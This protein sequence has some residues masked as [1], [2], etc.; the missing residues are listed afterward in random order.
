[1]DDFNIELGE[2]KDLIK[3]DKG[4]P[5]PI[6]NDC[7]ILSTGSF[8]DVG[9]L[10]YMSSSV[11]DSIK[12]F[13]ETYKHT[14]VG[15]V[16]LGTACMYDGKPCIN[17]LDFELCDSK[18]TSSVAFT[19][20]HDATREM[21][22]RIEAK[23]NDYIKL[24]WWH[25]HPGHGIFLSGMDKHIQTQF[26]NSDF[27]VALVYDPIHRTY[28]FFSNLKG[29]DQKETKYFLFDD[30]KN[31]LKK[32]PKSINIRKPS[33]QVRRPMQSRE[34]QSD[35]Q[36]ASASRTRDMNQ[37]SSGHRK[38]FREKI[39]DVIIYVEII[40]IAILLSII[41]MMKVSSPD[42][43]KTPTI[44]EQQKEVK[45][46]IETS[47]KL[48]K[49]RNYQYGWNVYFDAMENIDNILELAKVSSTTNEINKMESFIKDY[50]DPLW[51][52]VPSIK[53]IEL[54]STGIYLLNKILANFNTDKLRVNTRISNLLAK[55]HKTA[56]KSSADN[57]SKD[58]GS[59]DNGSKDNGNTNK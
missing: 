34:G 45:K 41:M 32:I 52:E 17:I 11:M 26:F 51:N 40:L 18:Q 31:M 6:K 2:S 16:L 47:R 57:G 29:L 39:K 15:G 38:K 36:F 53:R 12:D 21:D 48:F 54:N 8:D 56:D 50:L 33:E 7:M 10:I 58:N 30:E 1:M 59:K 5:Y 9:L 37:S 28:G 25:T 55:A 44:E 19:F 24:G 13:A 42:I 22:D 14:E 43:K 46:K 4:I 20:T 23:A 27:H 49:M 3:L 35:I